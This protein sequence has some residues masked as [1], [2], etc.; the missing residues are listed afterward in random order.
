MEK[1]IFDTN[2]YRYLATGKTNR[3]LDKLIKKI[4]HREQ[5]NGIEPLLNPIVARELLAHIA[6]K[7]DPSYKKCLMAIKAL[8]YHSGNNSDYSMIPTYELLI[9]KAFFN[10]VID[11]R[12]ETNTALG[13]IVFNFAKNPSQYVFTKFQRT[14]NL[15]AQ[16]VKCVEEGFADGMKQFLEIFD[17]NLSGWKAFENNP[18]GRKKALKDIRSKDMSIQLAMGNLFIVRQALVKE[19]KLPHKEYEDILAELRPMAVDFIDIFPEP[20]ALH[21]SVLENLVNSEFNL[22]EKSRSNFIWDILMMYYV[23]QNFIGNAK[24]IFVT[25]DKAMIESALSTNPKN[26]VLTF[27][28]YMKYLNLK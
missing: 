25:S 8:Y 24:T 13:Q 3:Q 22:Y 15:N 9:S 16:D 20:L 17:P 28:D 2:A 6:N 19:G 11:R 14:L 18:I 1:V 5:D 23:G 4:K 21:K 26:T 7:R 12:L 10:Q 27:D